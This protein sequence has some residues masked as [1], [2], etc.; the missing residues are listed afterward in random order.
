MSNM[1]Y[2]NYEQLH[3][4][5]TF[6][7]NAIM[8][9]PFDA[10]KKILHL[11][12]QAGVLSNYLC[13]KGKVYC[14][15]D[16]KYYNQINKENNPEVIIYDYIYFIKEF[17]IKVDYIIIEGY[18]DRIDNKKEVLEK[19]ISLLNEEGK[20]FILTDNKLGIKYFA[21]NRDKNIESEF[22]N[23]TTDNNL[24]S[25]KQW[26]QL[27]KEYNLNYKFYYPYPSYEFAEYI[28]SSTP[29][30]TDINKACLSFN[31]YRVSYFNEINAL[32]NLIDSKYF[33]DFTN[34]YLIIINGIKNIKYTKFARERK[35]EYQIYTNI[36][37]NKTVEKVAVY[38]KGIDHINRIYDFYEMFSNNNKNSDIKYC[39]VKKQDNKLL[40]D[41]IEGIS[42][43]KIIEKNV[44]DKDLKSIINNIKIIEKIITVGNKK[45]FKESELFNDIFSKQKYDL[46]NNQECYEFCNIDLIFDNI[47]VNDFYNVI[48]YEWVFNCI[49]PKSFIIFRTIFHSPSLSKLTTDERN[50]LY[51]EFGISKDLWDL[52]LKMEIS[53]QKYVSDNKLEDVHKDFDCKTIRNNNLKNLKIFNCKQNDYLQIIEIDS[54]NYDLLFKINTN[55]DIELSLD[56]KAIIKIEGIYLDD[57]PITEFETNADLVKGNDYYFY[58]QPKIFITNN[59]NKLVRIKGICYYYGESC[60]DNI[61]QLSKDNE[62]LLQQNN[63]LINKLNKLYKNIIVRI[64]AKIGE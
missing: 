21:G 24:Y 12:S 30:K 38:S 43:E 27:L 23:I 58:H 54:S 7:K 10:N 28:F 46:L 36:L 57:K 1:T 44:K 48:D 37:T 3:L 61:I 56:K 25:K 35:K 33:E 6:R 63:E 20:I 22:G 34:S 64:I 39:P 11:G 42:L 59:Y 55:D 26:E 40:F 13:K 62:H 50:S 16:N 8:W 9:Y 51:E 29:S 2:E 18:L 5:S 49:I 4:F 41:F 32:Q 19:C 60:I 17:D 15:E 47:I 52:Y 45:E 31:K 53:F 14:I